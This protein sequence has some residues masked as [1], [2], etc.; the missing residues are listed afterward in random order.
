MADLRQ[1]DRQLGEFDLRPSPR[2]LPM[3]GEITLEEWRC[4][5]ELVDNPVDAFVDARRSG[6]PIT[7][8][9]VSIYVPTA[10]SEHAQL[11]VR[12][13]GPGMDHGKLE[14]AVRA[15]W[16][17]HDPISHL[18]LFGM[19]FNIATA[20]LG[21]VTT[22]WT[23]RAND[24][25]WSGVSID[26]EQL[27]QRGSFRAPELRRPKEDARI[28]GTE[29][30][31][32]RLKPQYREWFSK[33]ANVNGLRRMLGKTYGAML[34][35]PGA[36]LR[37][38]LLINGM[39]VT[40]WEHCVWGDPANSEPRTVTLPSYGNI[41]AYQ[42]VRHDL[43]PRPYCVRCWTWLPAAAMACPQ[44]TFEDAIVERPRTV[45]GWL[46]VQRY[47]SADEFGID[48]LRNGRK[49]EL[50]NQDLFYWQSGASREREYPIDDPRNRGRIVGE[51]HIDH[52]RVTYTKDQ[53][54]RHD[55]AWEEMVAAVRG[56]GPL[57]P[58]KARNLGFAPNRSPLSLLYQAFRRSSPK[59]KVAGSWGRLLVVPDNERA[60]EMGAKFHRGD[61]TYRS[62]EKWWELVAA[63]DASLLRPEP[64]PTSPTTSDP[65]AGVAGGGGNAPASGAG[66][67]SRAAAA[68]ELERE[69]L[70]MLS[71]IFEFPPTHASWNVQAF[72]AAP[73]DPLLAD[74]R[75]WVLRLRPGGESQ[76]VVRTDDSV[77]RS[78]TFTPLDALLAE[79]ASRVV[80]LSRG[81]T[82]PVA[83]DQAIC[84]L[85]SRYA[86]SME[87]DAVALT[88]DGRSALANIL[89]AIGRGL[90]E[91]DSATL[92]S[93]LTTREQ[94]YVYERL[95][96]LSVSDPRSVIARG[97]FFEY[98]PRKSAIGVF[99]R[100]PELF[101]DGRCW[102]ARYATLD[103]GTPA[104][105]EEARKQ[106]RLYY[107][108]LLSDVVWLSEQE[109]ESFDDAT[110]ERILRA[111]YAVD[112]VT[113][114][115][116]TDTA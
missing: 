64:T 12:D 113:A 85:R 108:S 114:E 90:D 51:I 101:L 24:P 110:R 63:E 9:Q 76:F 96:S 43:P 93:E 102:P 115:T 91:A 3:L 42:I 17:S 106:T 81:S 25:E 112:I 99:E 44:C 15:G 107:G 86:A 70:P 49:I 97:R 35:D 7:D 116:P 56:L 19:G 20:R 8:P 22:V 18:G 87:L 109:P 103:Y 66:G 32:E 71:G 69:P 98:I 105:T 53:F 38:R 62:D 54:D 92:F 82:T 41:S 74:D 28:H 14:L 46:G 75:A 77:F 73:N 83:F 37:F 45:H 72:R 26:F 78:R 89:R 52:C 5:A 95:A 1:A 55:P 60:Q 29:V 84:G 34:R 21:T 39:E 104:A 27:Q 59:P 11:T 4:L 2:I 79:L 13:N 48:F 100:H 88:H 36:P 33:T 61:A 68:P 67:A 10:D 30:V 57:R 6:S 50:A 58:D 94:E 47:L 111:A 23:T 31:I 80:D 40:G 65:F 16:T